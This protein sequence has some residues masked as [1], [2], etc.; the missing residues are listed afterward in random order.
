MPVFYFQ[1]KLEIT[2]QQAA[3]NLP[4]K[5]VL[6]IYNSLANPAASYGECA[7]Y[8]G[9]KTQSEKFRIGRWNIE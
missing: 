1:L 4:R 5:E 2:L 9:S 6:S 7:R 8:C 3:G